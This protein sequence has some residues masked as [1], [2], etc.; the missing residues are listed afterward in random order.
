MTIQPLKQLETEYDI[1][2]P[3]YQE[4]VPGAT[5]IID[6]TSC[7][8]QKDNLNNLEAR[9]LNCYYFLRCRESYSKWYVK[10]PFLLIDNYI[11]KE[12]LSHSAFIIFLY[13]CRKANFD[14]HNNH[15]SRCWIN[16]R[17]INKVTG[18]KTSNMRKYIVELEKMGLIKC[19]TK[20]L[21]D[22]KEG[23]K[24]SHEFTINHIKILH[25]LREKAT[26]R[27]K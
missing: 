23:F 2:E 17:E 1:D 24:T 7:D 14:P 19:T 6:V 25:D 16:F 9:C 10:L 26:K 20:R 22:R 15:F 4:E 12:I 3:E 11:S 18:I 5:E 21:Y 13:L 27:K 8:L